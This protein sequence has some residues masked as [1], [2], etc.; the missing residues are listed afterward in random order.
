MKIIQS[1][2]TFGGD[3]KTG[4]FETTRVLI[5][6]LEKSY[7]VHQNFDYQMF[8]DEDGYNI[9]KNVVPCT[10]IDMPIL[11]RDRIKFDGKFQTQKLMEVPY[12]HVDL[13]AVLMELPE[14]KADIYCEKIEGRNFG[15]EI[16]DLKLDISNIY[17]LPC[18]AII[19]FTDMV[20]QKQ[21]IDTVFKLI[22][23]CNGIRNLNYK[24]CWGI[25]EVSLAILAKQHNKII[26]STTNIHY[27]NLK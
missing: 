23:K 9:I 24:H 10:V 18:S 4:G 11:C 2:K 25:E 17:E 13:D 19:G 26:K 6:E 12:I 14:E 20:F 5:N 15:N 16:N 7:K 22:D 1:L 21:Y 3:K 8:T 27:H